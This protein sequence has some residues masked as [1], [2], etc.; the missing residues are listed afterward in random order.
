MPIPNTARP[1]LS[2]V[3][4]AYRS[5]KVIG[6]TIEAV[7][8]HANQR[9]WEIEVIV[10]ASGSGDRTRD[11]AQE[12][13]VSYGNVVVLDTTEQFGKGGAVKAGMAAARGEICS[14]I[15]ADNGV[16]F[17]QIDRALPLLGRYDIVIGSRY[18]PGGDPGRRSIL[19]TLVSRGGNLLMQLALG[20][21][22]ADTR[23]PL[24]VFRRDVAKRLFGAS[25][26][27]GFGFDS[28]V[29]FLAGRLGYTVYELPVTWHPLEETT[30]NV[31]V[32][33]VR[34]LLELLQVRWNWVRGRYVH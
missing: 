13:A 18:L 19:R 10:A 15:D 22:Y 31:R 27:R 26:L 29:L 34:S 20:L 7:E 3:I 6:S 8:Q 25:Q 21:P 11:I 4:P 23:A 9:R 17:E 28:E 16:S 14:F 30:V 2:V 32:E 1:F 33:V 12:A 24:K 5:E